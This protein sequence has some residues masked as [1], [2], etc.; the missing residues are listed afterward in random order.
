MFCILL[1]TNLCRF[2]VDFISL[3]FLCVLFISIHTDMY[4]DYARDDWRDYES[5]SE[6]LYDSKINPFFLMLLLSLPNK[7]GDGTLK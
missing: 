1:V 7:F 5:P 6:R 2:I 4:D 3:M